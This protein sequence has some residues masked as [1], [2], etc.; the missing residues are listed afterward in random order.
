MKSHLDTPLEHAAAHRKA[1]HGDVPQGRSSTTVTV[2]IV[3]GNQRAQVAPAISG[4]FTMAAV[5]DAGAPMRLHHSDSDM[6]R[7]SVREV[8]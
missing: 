7:K 2:E 1:A 5:D 3:S 4:R 8:A 6:Q